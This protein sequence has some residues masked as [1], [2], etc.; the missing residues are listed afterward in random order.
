[1]RYMSLNNNYATKADHS[2]KSKFG[3]LPLST[4]GPINC[5]LS[6][7]SLLNTPYLNK[8]SAFPPDERREF[9]LTG[10][11]PQGVQTLEQQCKRAYEQYS[12]RP[13]D[14]AK[15][16]FLT[17]LKDQNEVLYYKVSLTRASFHYNRNAN[18][19]V[20]LL[21]LHLDEM[22]SIVYTPTEGDAI[23]NYSRL[24]RRPEGCYLNIRDPDHVH[25]N[26][27]QWGNPEDIDYIVVSDGEEILGIGDQGVG[28]ILI[29]VAKLVLTTL[30]AG[31]HPNRTLPVVLDCGTDNKELLGDELYLGLKEKRVRGEEY[32]KFVD[33]FVQ[34]AR[35][36]YPKA[37]IHFED[38]GLTNARKILYRY[39]P[40]FACFNDDV[41]G[42]GCVTLAAILSGLHVS[43]QKLKDLR[44]VVFGAGSAGLGIADQVRDAIATEGNMS[45]EE[46]AKQIWLIDKPGLLTSETEGV[47]D[48]QKIFTKDA[49]EWKDKDADLLSVIKEVRPNVLVGTSTKPGAFTEDVIRAMAEHHERPIVLPLSNPTR[50]HEAKPED[51]LKWT[52]GKALVATGS[53]F[54]PVKGPWGKDGSEITINVGEC[55]NSVVFPGIGL[56]CVLSRAK[57]LTD[58]MLVAAVEGVSSLSP[59]LKDS[60]APLLPDVDSV[61]DVSV[62]IARNVIQAAVKDGEATQE[63]IPEKEEDLEDWIREQMWDP[64]YRPLKKVDLEGATREARGELKKAGSVHRV[65]HT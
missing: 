34:S 27:A 58:R 9:N 62:R 38:F 44:M 22:M 49:S 59:V 4:A 43:K 61:R 7:T 23:Q 57:H 10:L 19:C 64:V 15:N 26:L 17:S 32:A 36:L 47:T 30:C 63:G 33:T 14:L 39:R 45:H 6:G 5:A 41:Q 3:D 11:L 56:G 35:K 13:D 18:S 37:Y 21:Q 46:A 31:V 8:G 65:G 28:G 2:K 55:N 24:F 53:P 54:P 60:T 48:S 40:D 1:M 25:H 50:L 12:S 51:I 42:T 52:N 16:T 29:S 20:K